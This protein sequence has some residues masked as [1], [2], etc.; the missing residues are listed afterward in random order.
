MH[1]APFDML[2]RFKK[3][4][5]LVTKFYAMSALLRLRASP[6]RCILLKPRRKAEKST[7]LAG[8]PP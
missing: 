2:R 7:R 4:R 1:L 8:L 5:G 6:S 3:T